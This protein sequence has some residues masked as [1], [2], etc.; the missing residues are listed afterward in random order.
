MPAFDGFGKASS[1]ANIA[2]EKCTP[3]VA[4]SEGNLDLVKEALSSLNLNPDTADE[5]GYT[6]V[7]AAAAY[8]QQHILRWL[9]DQNGV[10]VNAQDNDGDTPLHHV[11]CLDAAKFLI[12]V[13][14]VDSKVLNFE[15]K[16]AFL[17]KQEELQEQMD[18]EDEDEDEELKELVEYLESVTR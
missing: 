8:N 1:S 12:E 4:S 13:L 17:V 5:N 10:N 7:H 9:M 14:K 16:T 3:W 18:D 11:E 6:L 2:I 15:G